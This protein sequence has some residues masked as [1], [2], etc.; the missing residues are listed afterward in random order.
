MGEIG[1]IHLRSSFSSEK[2]FLSQYCMRGFFCL[3]WFAVF[4]RA[5]I[6]EQNKNGAQLDQ[7][8]GETMQVNVHLGLQF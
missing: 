3:F 2:S 7:I 6:I 1:C 4:P 5:T 8:T